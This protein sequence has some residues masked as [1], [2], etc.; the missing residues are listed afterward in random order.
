[1]NYRP[2]AVVSSALR[3]ALL[4]SLLF[5]VPAEAGTG[6]SISGIVKDQTSAGIPGAT[7]TLVNLDLKTT[8][9]AKTD[10]QGLYS[11]PNLPVGRYDMTIRAEGFKS[12]ERTNLARVEL[13]IRDG[14]AHH[15]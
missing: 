4:V 9:T 15:R 7:L 14:A 12:H 10:A 2:R 3:I 6:G 8:Y 5:S 1:M 13:R 11:F